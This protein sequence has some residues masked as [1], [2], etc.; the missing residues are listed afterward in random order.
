MTFCLEVHTEID[1]VMILEVINTPELHEVHDDVVVRQVDG[2]RGVRDVSRVQYNAC[3]TP[4][5]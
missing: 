5:G 1:S 4:L 3:V 2:T